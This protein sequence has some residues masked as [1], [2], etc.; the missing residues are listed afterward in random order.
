MPEGSFLR[1][2]T[3]ARRTDLPSPR[4]RLQG[5]VAPAAVGGVDV[6]AGRDDLVDA[7][8]QRLV[9]HEVGGGELALELPHRARAGQR[10]KLGHRLPD[11]RLQHRLG[12]ALRYC[13]PSLPE[14]PHRPEFCEPSF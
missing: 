9:E 10:S 13:W 4:R 2:S 14:N 6:G 7:V 12:P 5:G 3:R 1:T 11:V 8:Q